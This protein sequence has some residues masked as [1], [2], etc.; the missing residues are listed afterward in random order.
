[1]FRFCILQ[2]LYRVILNWPGSM[3]SIE[4]RNS[5]INPKQLLFNLSLLHMSERKFIHLVCFSWLRFF[6][7]FNFVFSFYNQVWFAREEEHCGGEEETERGPL[8][9]TSPWPVWAHI[10][11]SSSCGMALKSSKA[12]SY[13]FIIWFKARII[14]H[15]LK[16]RTP[17]LCCRGK[18]NKHLHLCTIQSD[19]A[20][21]FLHWTAN[22]KKQT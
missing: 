16:R 22:W 17:L 12:K 19:I 8:A 5:K 7:F 11:A 6:F 14:M 3:D 15:L 10:E 2:T 18:R 13:F 9:L 20:L 4:R 1:M 21:L